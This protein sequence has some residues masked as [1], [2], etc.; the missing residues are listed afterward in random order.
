MQSTFGSDCTYDNGFP[1][2]QLPVLGEK[3]LAVANDQDSCCPFFQLVEKLLD[4]VEFIKDEGFV[5]RF[6]KYCD[7]WF[8]LD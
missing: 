7:H 5:F 1:R 3:F 6:P 4:C 8:Q 2:D